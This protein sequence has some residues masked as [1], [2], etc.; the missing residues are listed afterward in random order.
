MDD[1]YHTH[2]HKDVKV[3]LEKKRKPSVH[4]TPTYVSWLYQ[5]EI[6]FNIL[7]KM[8]SKVGYLNPLSK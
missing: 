1:N 7:Q 5:V 4:Y 6:W 2:K 3:W 8:S